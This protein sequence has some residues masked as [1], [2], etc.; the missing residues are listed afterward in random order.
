[1]RSIDE[2]LKGMSMSAFL[3]HCY[4]DFQFFV[5]RVFAYD[6]APFHK[7]WIDAMAKHRFLCIIAHRGSGKTTMLGEAYVLWKCIFHPGF[8]A[9]VTSNEFR[10]SVK[11]LTTIRETIELNE[12]LLDYSPTSMRET[13]WTK[14]EL[15]FRNRSK[16]FCR[17]YTKNIRGLHVNYVLCDEG[18]LYKDHDI[19][20]R[21]VMPTVSMKRGSI[22]VIGTPEDEVDLLTE[23]KNN[24]EFW[25][26]T[27]K[28]EE[29]GKSLWP[30]KYPKPE[31]DKIRQRI[32]EDAYQKEYLCN[33]RA[34]SEASLYPPKLVFECFDY[35]AVFCE[36]DEGGVG[37]LGCDFAIATGPRADFDA[38]VF[39][40]RVAGKSI[41]KYGERHVGFPIAGKVQRIEQLYERFSPQR[42][43]C[44]P[45]SVGQAVIEELRNKG[46]P[47]IG[48]EFDAANRNKLLINL[49]QLI[50][51]KNLL[52]PRNAEDTATMTFTTKLVRELISIKETKTKAGMITYKSD[53]PH[54]DTVMALALACKGLSEQKGFVDFVAI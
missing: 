9:L 16:I 18:G 46:I 48:A 21:T 22:T 45:S 2:M 30:E 20:Y 6:F 39:V 15:V 29:N 31:L 49:R 44:D 41:L 11:V 12:F 54:D 10:Q 37:F 53:A 50:E 28:A 25:S 4:L 27:Y 3:T 40:E 24:P 42:I 34:A 14:T 52:I 8:Q 47:V 43:I 51:K 7:E 13:T 36:R 1:M 32:G 19:F 35:S 23:L 17:P 38:Y 33:P 26:K 5:E